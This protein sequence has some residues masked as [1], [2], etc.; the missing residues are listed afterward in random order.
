MTDDSTHFEDI[1]SQKEDVLKYLLYDMK[2]EQK[3][4]VSK[5]HY[6]GFY[7]AMLKNITCSV[8]QPDLQGA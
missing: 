4:G 8:E 1:H 2:E 6:F 5:S 7:D 3:V